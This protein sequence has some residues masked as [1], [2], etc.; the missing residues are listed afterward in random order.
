MTEIDGGDFTALH[1]SS[2]IGGTGVE[3]D[4]RAATQTIPLYPEIRRRSK[5]LFAADAWMQVILEN[6]HSGAD[7]EQSVVDPYNAGDAAANGFPA[8]VQEGFDIWLLAFQGIRSVG[9]GDITAA[10]V[11]V[12]P[13][14]GTFAIGIDD[15]GAPLAVAGSLNALGIS[16]ALESASTL[17]PAVLTWAGGETILYPKLRLPRGARIFF[18]TDSAG[19]AE[20]QAILTMGI[21]PMAMGQDII[22]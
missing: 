18:M 6:V 2:D 4:E 10:A 1:R 15:Q 20:F 14:I 12:A 21:F 19:A 3:F 22:G 17:I 7:A 11:V 13:G 8:A 16:T 9:V 5:P